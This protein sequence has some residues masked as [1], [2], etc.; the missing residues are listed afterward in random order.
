MTNPNN[1]QVGGSHYKSPGLLEHWDFAWENDY[2]QFEYC[3]SKYVY[4][5]YKKN[6]LEDL[7]KAGHHLD[8][9]LSLVGKRLST[10]RRAMDATNWCDA[11]KLDYHQGYIIEAIHVGML[12]EA[13]DALAKLISRQQHDELNPPREYVNPDL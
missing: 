11:H 4:R 3:I 5:C 10:G 1:I 13:K 6:G 9:Y 8:K 2:N 7:K 12:D